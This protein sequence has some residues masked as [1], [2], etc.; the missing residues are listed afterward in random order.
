MNKTGLVLKAEKNIVLLVTSTGE[1][2]KVIASSNPPKIGETYT[3][4]QK[5]EHNYL[6]HFTAAA[7]LFLIFLS[8]G[9]A[10]AYY[11][12]AAIIKVDINPSIELRINYFNRIIKS[13]PLNADGKILLGTLQ[14]ENKS[15]DEAL[16]LVIDQ[17]KKDNFINDTYIEQGKTVSIKISSNNSNKNIN[18]DKFEKYIVENKINTQINNN[19]KENKKE[20]NNNKPLPDNK[21]EHEKNNSP[22]NDKNGEK[23]NTIQDNFDKS[24]NN[25]NNLNNNSTKTKVNNNPM[26]LPNSKAHDNPSKNNVEDKPNKSN[27]NGKK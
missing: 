23:N 8:G 5:K 18:L 20:F 12:P 25:S 24:N 22:L 11:T 16:T 26:D 3:G 21:G 6:R 27:A 9:S 19:G 14:L 13:L 7:A 4:S 10:Y 2:V 1:F 17:A 15:I